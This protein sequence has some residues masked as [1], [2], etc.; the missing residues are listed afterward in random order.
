[1]EP[2]DRGVRG[3]ELGETIDD[4]RAHLLDPG[5]VAVV[6]TQAPP[7]RRTESTCIDDEKPGWYDVDDIIDSLHRLPKPVRPSDKRGKTIHRELRDVMAFLTEVFTRSCNIRDSDDA[8][9]PFEQD[10]TLYYTIAGGKDV[11]MAVGRGIYFGFIYPSRPSLF[12]DNQSR[13]TLRVLART[14][15]FLYLLQVGNLEEGRC[16][17]RGTGRVALNLTLL[18]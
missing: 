7:Q 2:A 17:M 16:T 12:R 11:Q 9:P 1:M 18:D 13:R 15:Q 10:A 3:A 4:I 5:R 14:Q 8:F 6:A